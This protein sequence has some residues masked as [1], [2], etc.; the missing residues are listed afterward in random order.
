MSRVVELPGLA[1]QGRG[2]GGGTELGGEEGVTAVDAAIAW[3]MAEASPA[4]S[5]AYA[6]NERPASGAPT[7]D[8]DVSAC[9]KLNSVNGSLNTKWSW[10]TVRIAAV[11]RWLNGTSRAASMSGHPG[12]RQV[13]NTD[14][15]HG[16]LNVS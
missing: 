14:P 10:S 8:S 12:A 13:S 9:P 2:V 16:S 3:S 11:M 6:W 4:A 1:A 5:S 15:G 7:P